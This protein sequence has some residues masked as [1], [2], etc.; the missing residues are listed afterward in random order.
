MVE[1]AS[2]WKELSSG[3]LY[4]DSDS[5][6]DYAAP[7]VGV[8]QIVKFPLI[9]VPR[10]AMV[11]G[12][13]NFVLDIA[14]LY[15]LTGVFGALAGEEPES[16]APLRASVLPCFALTPFWVAEPLFFVDRWGSF[17]ACGA[18]LHVLVIVNVGMGVLRAGGE[19][20]AAK[21]YYPL[22]AVTA[23]SLSLGFVL[24]S[25]VMRILNV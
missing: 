2:F 22:Q 13:I 16:A 24:M 11:Y 3:G 25:G 1:P 17:I 19:P 4:G 7:L 21:R 14:V 5:L 9:G 15:L 23:I 20:L 6:R 8:V 18:L 12:L 10:A